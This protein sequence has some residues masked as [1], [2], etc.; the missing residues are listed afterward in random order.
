MRISTINNWQHAII[1]PLSLPFISM[2]LPTPHGMLSK[3]NLQRQFTLMNYKHP[4][5]KDVFIRLGAVYL[6]LSYLTFLNHF[7]SWIWSKRWFI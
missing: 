6:H 5:I 7:S 2:V 3:L 1:F 4:Y